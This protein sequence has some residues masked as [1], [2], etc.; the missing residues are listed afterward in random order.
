MAE[1][2]TYEFSAALWP[3]E[4]RRDLWTFVTVPADASAQIA[5]FADGLRRGFG[6]VPV[7]ARIGATT[8][9]TSVFP[10]QSAG[11]YVLPVK[12]AVRTANGLEVGDEVAVW[13]EVLV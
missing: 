12:R 10:Q 6:A 9:R 7:R 2:L 4:V 1:S 11:P 13:I 3:W 5:E 8:W